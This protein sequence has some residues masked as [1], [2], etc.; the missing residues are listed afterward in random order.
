MYSEHEGSQ[1]K[2]L[3]MIGIREG[4]WEGRCG[5]KR[6]YKEKSAAKEENHNKVC[7]MS[8][9]AFDNINPSPFDRCSTR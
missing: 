8:A 2:K 1:D 5:M 7:L 6:R 9:I 4:S 3:V